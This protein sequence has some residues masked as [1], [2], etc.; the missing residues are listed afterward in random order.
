MTI[1]WAVAIRFIA[2]LDRTARS[3]TTWAIRYGLA[4]H[5]QAQAVNAGPNLSRKRRPKPEQ[6]SAVWIP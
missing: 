6:F 5:G 2:P 1:L 4:P 3:A